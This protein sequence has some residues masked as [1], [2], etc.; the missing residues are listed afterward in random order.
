MRKYIPAD[1]L[2]EAKTAINSHVPIGDVA[3]R[4]GI[5]VDDLRERLGMPPL[6]RSDPETGCDLWQMD[7]LDGV[8]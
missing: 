8:L 5:D 7:R 4:M 6:K 3:R 1:I 2:D